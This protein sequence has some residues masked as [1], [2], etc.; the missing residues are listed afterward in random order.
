MQFKA[1]NGTRIL[2][3]HIPIALRVLTAALSAIASL[4]ALDAATADQFPS[5]RITLVLPTGVGSPPDTFGRLIAQGLSTRLGQP[6]VV[7]NRPGAGSTIGTKD[8]ATATPDGYTLL[9]VN[10]A[11]AY[12]PLL[13]PNAGYDPRTSFTPVAGVASWSLM[14][15]V[16]ADLPVSSVR[17]LV[18]Y[19][20]ANPGK[21]NIGHTLGSP[22]QV[23]AEMFRKTTSAPVNAVPYPQPPQLTADLVS[24]QIQAAFLAGAGVNALVKNGKLKALA[25]TAGKRFDAL[26][27]VP[28]AGEAGMPALSY[29]P[30]DWVGIVAPAG[31]PRNIVTT[32]NAA[33]LQSLS[34]PEVRASIQLHG[35]D[36]MAL[37]EPQFATFVA[38][39]LT[40]WPARFREAG[41]GSK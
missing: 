1:E 40:K 8:V 30:T 19:A 36:V 10:S 16:N 32:L 15:L 23:L 18:G 24:G 14:L 4:A 9:Q 12:A 11:L 17:D 20:K 6:V 38:D 35:A 2:R 39:E 5:K 22:P 21:V 3:C 25:V 31:T 7:L 33:I 26:P 13:F 34:S 28:T 29:D 27:N 41:I 37:S